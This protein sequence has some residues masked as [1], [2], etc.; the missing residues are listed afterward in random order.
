MK[1]T[2]A[3]LIVATLLGASAV[4]A[5][6]SISTAIDFETEYIFRGLQLA[7]E[8]IM[9]SIDFAY[10]SFYFGI[11]SAQPITKNQDNEIDFYGGV[12]FD[13]SEGVSVD[14]GAT[15]YYYPETPGDNET[16]EI[17]GGFSF[18]VPVAPSVYLYY[19][20]DLDTFTLEGSVGHSVPLN[21]DASFD[22][23]AHVGWVN[24]KG[25][26]SA[27]YYGATADISYAF[28][29]NASGSIGVRASG[30]DFA[31]VTKDSN[32]WIGMTFSA[33]F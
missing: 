25:G 4:Q 19:D 2:I 16:I 10:D 3:S 30:N 6:L 29:E 26:D 22:L 23:G 20:F 18:D 21:E 32:F 17:Y 9:P 31:G 27:I 11:W 28:S 13:L 1:S 5:Q 15:L 7:D 33:G 8:S 14:F 12:G 24:P